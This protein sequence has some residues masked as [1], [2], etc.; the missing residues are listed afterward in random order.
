MEKI[1]EVF[2]NKGIV[3]FLIGDLGLVLNLPK[4]P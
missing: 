3:S 2:G 4:E 1:L